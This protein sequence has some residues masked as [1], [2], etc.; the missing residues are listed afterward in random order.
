[1]VES[2]VNTV[3]V[4]LNTASFSL[5]KYISGITAS[6]AKNIVAYRDKNG[7]F[8][9]REELKKVPRLGEQTFTQCAGFLRI[10]EADNPLDNTSVHPESYTLAEGILKEAGLELEDLKSRMG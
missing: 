9:N 8:K 10:S 4:D 5:L 3:G 7:A 2:C 6:V 1:M